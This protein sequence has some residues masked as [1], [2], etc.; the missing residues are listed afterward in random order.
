MILMNYPMRYL[1]VK[2]KNMRIKLIF[3]TAI[4]L[5]FQFV[6]VN[7]DV[8]PDK[9]S[10]WVN[11]YA[12]LLT[13]NEANALNT[14]LGYYE[15]STSTQIF[16]VTLDD[17]GDEPISMLAS[18]IGQKWGVGQKGKENGMLILIYPA[19]RQ[20]WIA[21]GYG[22][23]EFIPDAI[24]K[25]II[26]TEIKPAFKSGNYYQGLDKAT[27]VIMNLLSGVFTADQYKGNKD[28]GGSI[29]GI[30]FL[31]ILFLII[32]GSRKGGKSTSVG[33]NLPLW[34]ALGMMSASRHSHSGSFGGFS[35]GSGGFGGF[36]GGGGGS[37]GGGGAGGSW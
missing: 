22:L 7:A 27:T 29:G 23:E 32:F 36:S 12:K 24:S 10:A 4:I 1:S 26:E 30:I 9:P 34:M 14:K 37:F 19:D 13:N 35:S 18:E 2:N 3:L 20:I 31:I 8:F 33:K 15:D 21:T 5:S 11:D 6:P 28:A 17:H 16:I 25:R